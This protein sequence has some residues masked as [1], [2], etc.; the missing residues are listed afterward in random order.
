LGFGVAQLH[1][2]TGQVPSIHD[3]RCTTIA[4]DAIAKMA[5]Y[6]VYSIC[7]HL[8]LSAPGQLIPAGWLSGSARVVS[9]PVTNALWA[10]CQ[11]S[12]CPFSC[13]QGQGVDDPLEEFCA[14]A[15]D[16]DECRV[17]ED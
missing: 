7:M 5:E 1:A 12:L 3:E 6:I 11:V 8:Y 13:V 17:Y 9:L 10:G 16:A 4:L 14:S 15:P 2:F